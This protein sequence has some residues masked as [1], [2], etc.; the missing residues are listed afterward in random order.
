MYKIYGY[1]TVD[2]C[3]V[4]ERW[5]SYACYVITNIN[6]SITHTLLLIKNKIY[7]ICNIVRLTTTDCVRTF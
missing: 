3:A 5:T 6:C 2:W 7:K 4:K 1:F